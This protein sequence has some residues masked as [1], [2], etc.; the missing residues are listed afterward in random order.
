MTSE[1]VASPEEGRETDLLHPQM[2]RRIADRLGW[3][4][5]RPAQKLAVPPIVAGQHTLVIAPTAGGKTEAAFFPL[6]SRMLEVGAAPMSVVYVSPLKALINNVEPR[7][8]RY[9]AMADRTVFRWHGD[10][11]AGQRAAFVREPADV[12]LTTP[13][14]LEALF[15]GGRQGVFAEVRAIVIDEAHAFAGT[16]RGV[17]LACLL[18]RLAAASRHPVQRIALSAT[19]GNPEAFLDWLCGSD[20][21]ARAVV[22][23]SRS[24]IQRRFLLRHLEDAG[25]EDVA[26]AAAAHL[27]GRK[28][29]FFTDARRLAEALVPALRAEGVP[30]VIHHASVDRSLREEV[31]QEVVRAEESCLVCTSTMEMGVDVG[32]VE[33]VLQ[34]DAPLSVASY[35]QRMGRAGRRGKPGL[36]VVLTDDREA[37]LRAVALTSLALRRWVEPVALPERAWTV[38][39]HQVLVRVLAGRRVAVDD[40]YAD[41]ARNVPFRGIRAA[42][43]AVLVDHMCALGLLERVRHQVQLG[44]EAE[45]QFGQAHFS[46]LCSVFAEGEEQWQVIAGGRAIG[47]MD[48]SFLRKAAAEGGFMLAGKAWRA[49]RIEEGRRRVVVE[50]LSGGEGGRAPRWRQAGSVG[51]DGMVA[52][53]MRQLLVGDGMPEWLDAPEQR[54]LAELRAEA[55]VRGLRPDVFPVW[56]ARGFVELRTM[57]GERRNRALALALADAFTARA[58]VRWD[59]VTLRSARRGVRLSAEEVVQVVGDWATHGLT[60]S[61]RSAI[62]RGLGPTPGSRFEPYLPQAF[63]EEVRAGERADADGLEAWLGACRP[64]LVVPAVYAPDEGTGEVDDLVDVAE[65]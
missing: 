59:R 43:F 34:L 17:Q 26:R 50:G 14:S 16:D 44:Y 7:L 18:E 22:N 54:L 28:A 47:A 12:L 49:V 52:E 32:D 64:V 61:D 40:M 33:A 46:S 42:E 65:A 21:G 5:L 48:A 63:A 31:E 6:L 4:D 37:F 9:A 23:P 2:R 8:A 11:G 51:M 15:M 1:A 55:S 38:L 35:L 19:L 45:R 56:K 25:V 57:A 13:E 62:L 41:L 20:Q 24:G 39:V 58:T 53:E 3:P 30:A 36:M 10:V 29:M 27:K 60:S